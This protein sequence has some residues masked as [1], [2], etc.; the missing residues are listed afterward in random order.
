VLSSKNPAQAYNVWWTTHTI[1]TNEC[2]K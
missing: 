2:K 1:S